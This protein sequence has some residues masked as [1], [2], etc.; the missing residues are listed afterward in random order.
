MQELEI[1][2][3]NKDGIH[4]RSA[5]II[6]ELANKYSSCDIKITTEDGRKADAKSTIEIIILGIIYKEKIKITVVGKKGKLAIKN[7]LNLLKYNFS[8]ELQK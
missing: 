5:N 7:L 3:I 8:K 6:A 4:S 1:E 2:I